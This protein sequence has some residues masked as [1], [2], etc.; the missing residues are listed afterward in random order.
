MKK[1]SHAIRGL[2]EGDIPVCLAIY[3]HY[4]QKTVYTLEEDPLSLE[5]FKER[6]LAIESKNPF[7]VCEGEEGAILGFCYLHPF[8]ERSAFKRTAELSIYVDKDHLREG[9]GEAL[10]LSLEMEARKK[11]LTNLVAVI[12][13]E[14]S[15]SLSFHYRNGFVLEGTLKGVAHKLG[16][17]VDVCYLRKGLE[18]THPF[19]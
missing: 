9:V 5:T 4:I 1:E 12:T 3:N 18:K 15:S 17:D 6:C 13:G 11:E 19:N 8:H 14:N 10:Y 2:R 16:R 7:L